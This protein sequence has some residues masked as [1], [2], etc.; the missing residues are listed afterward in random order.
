MPGST[1]YD[2][3][4]AALQGIEAYWVARQDRHFLQALMHEGW[5]EMWVGGMREHEAMLRFAK[6][7]RLGV[8]AAGFAGSPSPAFP[9]VPMARDFMAAD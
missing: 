1:A 5:W 2:T 8:F 6:E 3:I 9:S 7:E 4:V